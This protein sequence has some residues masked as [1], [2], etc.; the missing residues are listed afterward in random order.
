MPFFNPGQNT[1]MYFF[2]SEARHIHWWCLYFLGN[3]VPGKEIQAHLKYI[4]D[5]RCTQPDH[6]L[7]VLTGADRDTWTDLRQ[8]IEAA[9]IRLSRTLQK[10]SAFHKSDFHFRIENASSAILFR[11][12]S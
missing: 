2:N 6:P 12:L 3:I 1:V 9:G 8:Q 7:G 5:D 10:N 11:K 4:M